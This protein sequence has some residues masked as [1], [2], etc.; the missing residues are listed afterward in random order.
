MNGYTQNEMSGEQASASTPASE[1]S[2]EGF[3]GGMTMNTELISA[4]FIAGMNI[5]RKR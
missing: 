5:F 1:S 4:L 2:S 3:L